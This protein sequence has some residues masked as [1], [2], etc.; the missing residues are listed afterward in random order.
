[1]P[2][3][4]DDD[5]PADVDPT[6]LAIFTEH[7]LDF[8]AH[9]AGKHGTEQHQ[10]SFLAPRAFWSAEEKDA[11]FHGLAVHSR[12]RP[13]LIAEEIK[14]KTLA[15]VCVY[16]ALLEQGDIEDL[17]SGVHVG[18]HARLHRKDHPSA[19]EVSDKW[20]SFEERMADALMVFQSSLD[21]E[22]ITT[23][24]D[25]E[26]HV[27]KYAVRAP[28]GSGRT[29]SQARDREGEKARREEFEQWLTQRRKEW[30]GDEML[31]SMDKADLATLDRMLRED[32]E[33][34]GVVAEA[35]IHH[36][37]DEAEYPPPETM[38]AEQYSNPRPVSQLGE[39]HIDPMLLALSQVDSALSTGQPGG[40]ADSS[41]PLATTSFS[42]E[43]PFMT[44][45]LP[46]IADAYPPQT[47][48]PTAAPLPIAIDPALV[49]LPDSSAA[50][51]VTEDGS[52][53]DGEDLLQMSP[54][55]RRRYQ[56]RLYMRRKRAQAAGTTANEVA[57]RLKPGRRPKQHFAHAHISSPG[58]GTS[59]QTTTP[60]SSAPSDGTPA[61]PPGAIVDR[62][63]NQDAQRGHH[64]SGAT[65][66]YKRQAQLTSKGIDIQRLRKEGLDFFHLQAISKLMGTYNQLH[67]IP[68]SIGSAISAE[69][70]K[71]LRALVV[72]FVSEV[73]SRAIIS[74]EQER[75]AKLQ[76]KAWRLKENQ[77]VT[78]VNV[79]HALA[80][81][82]ADSLDKSAH[83]KSLLRKLNL[84]DSSEQ[85]DAEVDDEDEDEEE[86]DAFPD[87]PQFT[88]G[89]ASHVAGSEVVVEDGDAASLPLK[90]LPLLRSIFPPFM[91]SPTSGLH[92]SDVLDSLDPSVY[93]P[94]PSSSLLSIC[95]EPPHNE[96]M[97]PEEDDVAL[98]RELEEDKA[99]DRV[100]GHRD[101]EVEKA[102]WA[103]VGATGKDD[104]THDHPNSD[105]KPAPAKPLRIVQRAPRKRKRQSV[106]A[107]GSRERGT[108]GGS[109]SERVVEAGLLGEDADGVEQIVPRG[110]RKKKAKAKGSMSDKQLLFQEPDPN[111]R[112]KSAVYIL[113]SD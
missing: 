91:N 89:G 45:P 3:S 12:F 72:R 76:T 65:L 84:D 111:G 83:F 61:Q 101:A 15:D 42:R 70:L 26:I 19:V 96:D 108:D 99:L 41:A 10:A 106:D 97:L 67:D 113:D 78:T 30:E 93:M 37:D 85:A 24:R 20:L 5:T 90:P 23:A 86:G 38:Q 13:D 98:A 9:L 2:R 80:L 44:L 88:V 17:K 36:S 18:E 51:S 82:G 64:T 4:D 95:I 55:A 63:G 14:T 69:T 52:T 7:V 77:V 33:G 29:T 21:Q 49:P 25:E 103:R 48:A 35:N 68:R 53:I 27:R 75:I 6:Y 47:S 40:P 100:D 87:E 8:R 110:R 94:W 59:R 34:R 112:I 39:E 105:D 81:Y 16:I 32:E 50:P 79:K 66:P 43:M 109:A 104:Q 73:M 62:A 74:R 54:A 56:K 31:L 58:T 46:P 60:A 22:A 11:F 107:D 71:L 1:M 102:L 92:A 57:E 28:R